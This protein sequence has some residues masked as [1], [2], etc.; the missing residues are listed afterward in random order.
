MCY[1]YVLKS[2]SD[3]SF[4][5]GITENVKKRLEEHN[6]GKLKYTAN[7]RPWILWHIRES[8]SMQSARKEEI[9]LKKKNRDFK[10]NLKNI[11]LP[12]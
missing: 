5:V 1:T 7:K 3:D 4:Y 9:Y 10:E 8:E 6:S 2:K 11:N 12:R